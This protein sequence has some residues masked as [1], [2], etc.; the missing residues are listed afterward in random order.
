MKKI[1]IISALFVTL[2]GNVQVL[3]HGS[4]GSIVNEAMAI[5][6]AYKTVKLLTFQ[7]YGFG[8][9]KLDKSWVEITKDDFTVKKILADHLIVN[10]INPRNKQQLDI[11]I[12]KDQGKIIKIQRS[13]KPLN[14]KP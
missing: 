14:T 13:E 6:A 12:A 7:D 9:G 2:L 8:I 10:V 3:A 4:R 1:L 5:G 11:Y